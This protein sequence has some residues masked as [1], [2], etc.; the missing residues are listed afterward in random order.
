[1]AVPPAGCPRS[2]AAPGFGSKSGLARKSNF[3]VE[4]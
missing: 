2:A 4:V 3:R 1:V